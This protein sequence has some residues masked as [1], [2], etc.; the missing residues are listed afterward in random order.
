M[1]DIWQVAIMHR[2]LYNLMWPA[3]DHV[4][5]Y[6][7]NILIEIMQQGSPHYKFFNEMM[8]KKISDKNKM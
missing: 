4:F 8:I 6:A 3:R 2:V 7:Q 1:I 5:N